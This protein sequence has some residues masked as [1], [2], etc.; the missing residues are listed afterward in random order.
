MITDYRKQSELIEAETFDTPIH[1]IG[2][3]ALGSWLTF[4]LL[5][6]GF[7]NINVYDFD[8]IE[9]HNI[10]NQMFAENQIGLKKTVAM[11]ETYCLNFNDDSSFLRLNCNDTRVNRQTASNLEGI[12]FS[13]VDNMDTRKR[14]YEACFKNGKAELWIEGRIGLF[15]SYIYT[16]TNRDEEH[17]KKYEETLYADE[18]AEVS[19]CGISQTALP[20]AVNCASNMLMQMISY[21]RG[22]EVYNEILYQMPDMMSITKRW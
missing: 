3:G 12:V 19:A 20:S 10:P 21:I 9:E 22:N 15:G 6:M 18:E 5:K 13:C 11:F 14:L 7:K 16:L 17:F 4:F 1:V 2:C 8:T